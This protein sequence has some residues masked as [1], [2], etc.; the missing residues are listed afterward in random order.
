MEVCIETF[1]SGL[2]KFDLH[3]IILNQHSNFYKRLVYPQCCFAIILY[4]DDF[5]FSLA[6]LSA[7]R[8]R[9]ITSRKFQ[10]AASG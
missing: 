10:S 2:G 6:Q 4:P 7:H 5:S 3:H 8:V 9:N 1:I